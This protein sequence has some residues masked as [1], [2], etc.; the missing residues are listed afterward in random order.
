[1]EYLA[2]GAGGRIGQATSY[3][4]PTDITLPQGSGVVWVFALPERD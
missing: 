3:A 1:M 4:R 2:V